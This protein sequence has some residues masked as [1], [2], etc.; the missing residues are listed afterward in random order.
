[1]HDPT[2]PPAISPRD[3][4][5][6]LDLDGTL[7]EIVARPEQAV[8]SEDMR[9]LI[10]RLVAQT[11]GAVA[12][13]SG[14]S[15]ADVDRMLHPLSLPS[16]GSHGQQLRGAGSV[17]QVEAG[18]GIDTTTAQKIT[19]FATRAGLL[20]EHKPGS[21]ALHYRDAPMRETE[22]RALIDGLVANDDRY[23]AVHG[24][25]VSEL[26]Q[27][28]CDKGTAIAAFASVA[29]FAGK[30]PVMVG[31]DVTD[32]D[33]FRS[34]QALGGFGI[35]IG[36]GQTGARHRLRSIAALSGWLTEILR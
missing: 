8:I 10:Y 21:V 30:V 23:R 22:S 17:T 4:A 31:D 16:A 27:R 14:R 19:Q 20:A 5:F 25:M 11:D 12:I 26:A 13:V 1:M 18:E 35:K 34:A 3:C 15:L 32:E 7:A 36:E 28:D 29:P 2:P 24:K 9:T 6:Y 33:G